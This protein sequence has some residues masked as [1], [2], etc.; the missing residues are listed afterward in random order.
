MAFEYLGTGWSYPFSYSKG[1][2]STAEGLDSVKS[3]IVT[4]VSTRPGELFM[5]PQIG[6][7]LWELVFKNIDAVFYALATSY[8]QSAITDQEP[9]VTSVNIN[10]STSEDTPNKVD[11]LIS[12]TVISSGVTDSVTYTFDTVNGGYSL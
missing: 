1:S 7:R 5:S 9:R 10:F 8:I 3:S 11:I 4:I 6:C 2:V 12:Y